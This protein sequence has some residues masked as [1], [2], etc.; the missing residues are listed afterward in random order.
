MDNSNRDH[1]RSSQAD[2]R[3]NRYPRANLTPGAARAVLPRIMAQN[4]PLGPVGARPV[5]TG[6]QECRRGGTG[7][8]AGAD[9][10]GSPA[11]GAWLRSGD[12]GV[13]PSRPALL[14]LI[15]EWQ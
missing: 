5:G 14:A 1:G 8:Q 10:L 4:T 7:G 9:R 2:K 3:G 12:R 6:A 15:Y 11:Q 13:M